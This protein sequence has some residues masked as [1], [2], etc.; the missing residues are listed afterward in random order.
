MNPFHWS[1]AE[2]E[3]SHPFS[4]QPILS[5][6][7]DSF[8]PDATSEEFYPPGTTCSSSQLSSM[9]HI[10]EEGRGVYTYEHSAQFP[11]SSPEHPRF[12]SIGCSSTPNVGPSSSPEQSS[13]HMCSS[14]IPNV[15]HDPGSHSYQCLWDG[16]R[17]PC[18]GFFAGSSNS[19]RQHLKHVHAFTPTGREVVPCLWDGC[20]RLLQRENVVRHVLTVD[21]Q[22]KVPCPDC[23]KDLCRRDV[24]V[25]HARKFCPARG[26]MKQG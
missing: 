20:G 11:P 23:G 25:M 12:S 14:S 9:A 24:R 17:A 3:T 8:V 19:V 5:S 16:K 13:A 6:T 7:H 21:L 15:S 18:G 22:L 4:S 1:G 2:K 26:R 10:I